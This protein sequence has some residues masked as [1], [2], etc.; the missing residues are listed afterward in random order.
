MS[1][2]IQFFKDDRISV[3]RR[4]NRI[5]DDS[6]ADVFGDEKTKIWLRYERVKR[7]FE[8]LRQ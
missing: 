7:D 8:I 4:K 5:P 3:E 2:F 1:S 6:E